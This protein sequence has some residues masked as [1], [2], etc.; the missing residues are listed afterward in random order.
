V[1]LARHVFV[2]DGEAD[3]LA[4]TLAVAA[5]I[6]MWRLRLDVVPV[7]QACGLAGLVASYV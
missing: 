2:V 5:F 6:A 7:I 3:W 1:F 4:V